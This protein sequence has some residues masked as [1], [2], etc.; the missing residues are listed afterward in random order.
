MDI[1]TI[2]AETVETA[3][4]VQPS[5]PAEGAAETIV[6][7]D[8]IW[9]HIIS[10]N[11]VEALAFLSFGAVC[12]FYGWRIFKILVTISF[13]LIGLV[14]GIQLNTLLIGGNAIWLGV[15]F[16]GVFAFLSVPLMRWAVCILG[17]LAGGVL[18]SGAWYACGLT[19]QYIWAGALVGVV[20][21][22]MISFIIFKYAVILFTS[23]A[24]SSLIVVAVLAIMYQHLGAAEQAEQ[25]VFTYKWSLPVMLLAPMVVGILLQNKFIKG[26]KN[27][28]I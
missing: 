23:M 6:P 9:E 24:G 7:I 18:T 10:L 8:L 5:Q 11:L 15:I 21:G 13:G 19:E 3:G 27:W 25:L 14:A 17:A 20:A 1:F 2:L 12:L 16:M 26:T 4:Q 22:G 28:N